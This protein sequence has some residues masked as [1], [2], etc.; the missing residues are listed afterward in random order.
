MSKLDDLR[1]ELAELEQTASEIR[2][3]GDVIVSP[4]FWLDTTHNSKTTKTY[5]RY[6]QLDDRGK[7]TAVYISQTEHTALKQAIERGRELKRIQRQIERLQKQIARVQRQSD[8]LMREAQKL[9]LL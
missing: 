5:Y 1:T 6:Y 7:K 3:Q 2:G 9:G 8:R 4:D